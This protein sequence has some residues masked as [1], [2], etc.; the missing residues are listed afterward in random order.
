MEQ[1]LRKLHLQSYSPS[2]WC[3]FWTLF[4]WLA[5]HNNVSFNY[6]YKSMN[7]WYQ[8]GLLVESLHV[9]FTLYSAFKEN[10]H[11]GGDQENES[12]MNQAWRENDFICW[13]FVC[14]I[15]SWIKIVDSQENENINIRKK[16]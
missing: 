15:D 13:M 1:V 8:L 3:T 6:I 7:A 2:T 16:L 9:L 14:S 10:Q 11:F 5:Q 4:I 12:Y